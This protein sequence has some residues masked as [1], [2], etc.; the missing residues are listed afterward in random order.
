MS[1]VRSSTCGMGF[2]PKSLID[3]GLA[4]DSNGVGGSDYIGSLGI[5]NDLAGLYDVDGKTFGGAGGVGGLICTVGKGFC[6]GKVR[7]GPAVAA[8]GI[9]YHW[10]RFFQPGGVG[11][12]AR[13]CSGVRGRSKGNPLCDQGLR[14]VAGFG[15]WGQ[16]RADRC[17][18]EFNVQVDG[19]ESA[20]V[21]Q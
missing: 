5:A 2:L 15:P 8:G 11:L 16:D 12:L 18:G 17:R 6:W 14:G 21:R 9:G 19:G 4:A 10:Y 7:V 3:L 1:T 13:E 20:D